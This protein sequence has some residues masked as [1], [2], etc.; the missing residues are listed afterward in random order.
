MPRAALLLVALMSVPAVAAVSPEQVYETAQRLDTRALDPARSFPATGQVL[1]RDGLVATFEDGVFHPVVRDDGKVIGLVFEGH[2][3]AEFLIPRG[4]ETSGWQTL[5]DF[6]SML[7]E[8]TACYLRFTDG[9]GRELRGDAEWTDVGDADG[10]AFRLFEQRTARLEDPLWTRTNPQ[11]VVDQ[12]V[13]LYGGGHVGGHLLAEF[14]VGNNNWLSYLHN[15][16]GALMPGESTAVY[17]LRS[18]GQVPPEINVLSSFGTSEESQAHFDVA[19]IDMD[20][21]FPTAKGGRDLVRVN[22]SAKL[23]LVNVRPYPMKGVVLELESQRLLCNAQPDDLKIKVTGARDGAG[24]QLGAIHRGDRLFIPLHDAVAYGESVS[25]TLEW[26]GPMTQGLVAQQPDIYYS[27]IGPWAWYPRNPHPD[28]HGSTVRLHLPRFLRGI[29]PGDLTEERLEKDGWHF[30]FQEPSGVRALGLVVGDLVRAKDVD[31]GSNPKIIT[32]FGSTEQEALPNSAK[33]ARG[34]L[35]TVSGLWGPYPYSTL[36]VI[37]NLSFP[38]GNWSV[39]VDGEGGRWSCVPPEQTQ[40]WQGFVEGPSGMLLA[41]FPTTAPSRDI[42]EAR[43]YDRLVVDQLEPTRFLRT[44]DLARQWWGHLVPARTYRDVWINEAFAQWTALLVIQTGVGR[45][46]LKQR[47]NAMRVLLNEAQTVSPPLA[48]GE[49]LGRSFHAQAWTRGPLLVSWLVDRLGSRPFGNMINSLIR[50]GA[51]PGVSQELLYD[52]VKEVGG[53]QM[54]EQLRRTV[55]TNDL[56]EVEYDLEFDKKARQVTVVLRHAG[57]VMPVDLRIEAVWSP[58]SRQYKIASLVD[59]EL[60]FRWAF[61]E[62]PKRILVDPVKSGIARS[63]KKNASIE[64]PAW[65]EPG[66]TE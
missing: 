2:G 1:R 43:G 18:T 63:V 19:S 41:A 35:E 8:F 55:E 59:E 11:L 42:T 12:L 40:P 4:P 36:H 6:S 52:V 15:P 20:V 32:W 5:T 50:R 25:L 44:A 33:N 46:A 34:M 17:T 22:A 7:Q 57:T 39:G 29:A 37:E 13:D 58:K 3:N 21:H 48:H 54:L 24:N 65:P 28:R 23:D 60:V 62:A 45:D 26:G 9:T 30:T 16:R 66:A 38:A 47:L 10:S 51:G 61:D 14:K 53:G 56:P 64:V 49:R 27:E 31:H